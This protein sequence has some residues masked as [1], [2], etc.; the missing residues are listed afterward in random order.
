M[1]SLP[2]DEIEAIW[3]RLKAY[4]DVRDVKSISRNM[5]AEE[6]ENAMVTSRVP[7]AREKNPQAMMG[8]LVERGFPE[9]AARNPNI[10]EDVLQSQIIE[11]EV[12]GR[13]R[14][15][16][17]KGTPSF[18]DKKGRI[19]RGGQFVAGT[20]RGKAVKSLRER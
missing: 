4:I 13:T 10:I 1:D 8:F 9:R 6:I 2:E 17:K 3:S 11:S 15:R 5:I 19:I 16:I 7:T 18:K 14:F 12:R 20:T